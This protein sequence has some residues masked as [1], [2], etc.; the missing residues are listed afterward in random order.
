MFET[1]KLAD[2]FA[3][4]VREAYA[5]FIIT[6]KFFSLAAPVVRTIGF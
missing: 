5:G 4:K 2:L 1:P 3:S 6:P